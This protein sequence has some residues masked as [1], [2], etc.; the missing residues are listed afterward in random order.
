MKFTQ[1]AAVIAGLTLAI[2][3]FKGYAETEV[4]G[5][6]QDAIIQDSQVETKT[7]NKKKDD[8]SQ[9]GI[10]IL[11]TNSNDNQNDSKA[12][13]DTEVEVESVAATDVA[14]TNEALSQADSMRSAR[15]SAEISTEQRIVEKLEASRLEDE[16]RRADVLFG[17]RFEA[18]DSK[19]V[20]KKKVI[21]EVDDDDYGQDDSVIEKQ[22]I[23]KKVVK[24]VEPTP[25]VVAPAH[26]PVQQNTVA[27]HDSYQKDEGRAY[28]G[29]AL[30]GMSYDAGNVE[31]KYAAGVVLGTELNSHFAV[32]GSFLYSSHFVDT[33]WKTDIYSEVNQ[34]DFGLNTKY[35][36]LTGMLRPY[37]GLGASYIYRNYQD[38]VISAS[39]SRMYYNDGYN[40][41]T[42]E[43][44]T[45]AVDGNIMV[46][47]DVQVSKSFLLG[48]EYKDR[49][50]VV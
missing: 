43:A 17:D 11:N 29:V 24:E 6:F 31:S 13:V 3:S 16:R 10:I 40:Q 47:L 23:V 35:R 9:G 22:V 44:N 39:G 5:D 8:S 50:S 34:Y 18:L 25:V 20:I 41:Y 30:G 45:H 14:A 46:G 19:K 28:M 12:D 42:G 33:F 36:F 21:K 15:K 26:Y 32:E 4:E 2:T 38:R 7:I 37:L 48:A 49:K 27:I 1:M